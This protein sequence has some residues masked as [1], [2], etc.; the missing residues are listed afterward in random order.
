MNS[1]NF[2]FIFQFVKGMAPDHYAYE[3]I[4]GMTQYVPENRWPLNKVL[5]TI[6]GHLKQSLIKK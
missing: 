3:M 5:E 2:Y 4:D 6:E 1:L